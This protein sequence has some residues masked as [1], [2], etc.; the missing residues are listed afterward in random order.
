LKRVLILLFLILLFAGC[1][2][3]K[4]HDV[5]ISTDE[6]WYINTSESVSVTAYNKYRL[7]KS[8]KIKNN[9]GSYTIVLKFNKPIK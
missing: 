8:D 5:S 4:T 1:D 2:T 7:I 6:G 3:N 9:D